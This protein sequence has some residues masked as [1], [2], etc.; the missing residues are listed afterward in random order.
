MGNLSKSISDLDYS[1]EDIDIGRCDLVNSPAPS[2][3]EYTN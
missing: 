3:V 2:G 1:R